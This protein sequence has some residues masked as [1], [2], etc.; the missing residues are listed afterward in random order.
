MA[1]YL[2]LGKYSSQ[3]LKT[4]SAAR[5]RKAEHIIGRFRG[6]IKAMYAL[7]GNDDLVMIVELPGLQE[8]IKVS[9]G[10]TK[11]TGINFTTYPAISVGEF[12]KLVQE[13]S[14]I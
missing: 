1:T 4:A 8:A 3:S 7:L 10:L 13:V 12:D 11:L 14:N 6:Q 2:F 9:M 5:T